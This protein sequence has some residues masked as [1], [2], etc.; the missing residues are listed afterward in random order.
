MA[1]PAAWAVGLLRLGSVPFA[2]A[3]V[4]AS[5]APEAVA[6]LRQALVA[7]AGAVLAF[8]GGAQQA[9]AVADRSPAAAA[10]RPPP[11]AAAAAAAWRCAAAPDDAPRC[12]E[13]LAAAYAVQACL[14]ARHPAWRHRAALLVARRWRWPSPRSAPAA[15]PAP[16]ARPSSPRSPSRPWAGRG[17]RGRG[18]PPSTAV[19]GSANPVKVRAVAATVADYGDV[20]AAGAPVGGFDVA[21][22]V[23]DQ[24]VGL[25]TSGLFEVAGRHLDA[26]VCDAFDG[27]SHSLGVSCAFEIPPD[28]LR[29]LLDDGMDLSQAANASGLARD[30]KLGAKGGLIAI[31]TRDRVTRTDYTAQAVRMALAPVEH[32]LPPP[33]QA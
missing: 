21:S 3:L 2:V 10:A 4:W 18:G 15:G 8:V 28:V 32:R 27:N 25:D 7:L 5:I 12:A 19:V 16:R 20:V 9:A 14:E 31:L 17:R 6:P 26:C 1:T 24:P 23:A 13:V 11:R 22:G 30:A 33:R 29:R